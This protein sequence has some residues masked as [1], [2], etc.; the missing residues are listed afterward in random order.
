MSLSSASPRTHRRIP[1]QDRSERR[2][3]SMLA[4][5]AAVIAEVGYEAATMTEI[6][7]RSKASIGSLYQYFPNKEAITTALRQQYVRELEE[8]WTSLESQVDQLSPASLGERIVTLF[9]EFAEERPAFIPMLSAPLRV[10]SDPAARH[11]LREN[12]AR[13]FRRKNPALSPAESLSVAQVTLQTI[14]GLHTLAGETRPSDAK[15]VVAEFGTLL[16]AYLERRLT[17]AAVHA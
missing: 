5:A 1:V 4:Q 8:R 9:V 3:A 10:R 11:R 12:F 2:V 13:L 17:P 16:G 14:K 15:A 6:A 7:A